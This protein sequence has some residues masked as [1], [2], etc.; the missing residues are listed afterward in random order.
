M[1]MNINVTQEQERGFC[2]VLVLKGHNYKAEYVKGEQLT[3][4][5]CF[6]HPFTFD[7]PEGLEIFI[8]GGKNYQ[9]LRKIHLWST[10]KSMIGSWASKIKSL[11]PLNIYT[12]KGV[13]EEGE[14]K[15]L[16]LKP[17][18]RK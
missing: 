17:G 4:H 11:R 10:D 13:F 1:N 5:L 16:I 6:S 2:K 15:N 9:G 7:I 14:D 3:L 12:G 18:K 8:P